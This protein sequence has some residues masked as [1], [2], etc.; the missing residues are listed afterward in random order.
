MYFRITQISIFSYCMLSM[1][2][3][4]ILSNGKYSSIEHRSLVH[5]D[6]S[7]MSWAGF[8]VPP[9]DVVIAPRRELIDEVDHPP[10]Y[11]QASFGDYLT[12][13]C[14]KGLDGKNHVHQAK[15]QNS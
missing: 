3:E 6:R 10:L 4:Q 12:K 15:H 7:R 14:K 9:T 13:F 2:V 5:K 1:G 8:C 11:Q